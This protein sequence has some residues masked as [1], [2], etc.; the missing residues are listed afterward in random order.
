MA[1]ADVLITCRVH[2]QA[3]ENRISPKPKSVNHLCFIWSDVCVH[4]MNL[5]PASAPFLALFWSSS[6]R[7]GTV[8]LN[9]LQDSPVSCLL[10]PFWAIWS[11][12]H[13]EF[14]DLKERATSI[15][16]FGC[17]LLVA[18]LHKLGFHR[19]TRAQTLGSSAD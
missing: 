2:K 14:V 19:P 8:R 4:V 5:S 10:S 7:E 15:A 11:S 13:H 9:A 16:L 6:T 12:M 18:A 3:V 17:E 1:L